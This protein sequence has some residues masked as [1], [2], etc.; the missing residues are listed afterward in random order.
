MVMSSIMIRL[1]ATFI[2]HI[3]CNNYTS[4]PGVE[5]KMDTGGVTLAKNVCVSPALLPFPLLSVRKMQPV[6]HKHI[7]YQYQYIYQITEKYLPHFLKEYSHSIK[8][9]DFIPYVCNTMA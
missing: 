6:G 7:P 3:S 1:L 9:H 8:V 4:Q 5:T 2:Y